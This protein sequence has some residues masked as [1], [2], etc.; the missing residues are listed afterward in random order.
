[1]R[2][3]QRPKPSPA[4]LPGF[5]FHPPLRPPF[6][7]ILPLLS[8]TRTPIFSVDIPSGWDVERGRQTLEKEGEGEGE[9]GGT[10]DTFEPQ[11]LISLTAPKEG[12]RE[13]TGRH[14]LGGR[15]I[16]E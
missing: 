12:V 5:S 16:P 10:V 11:G 6:T 2:R 4:D 1:M 15:F 7:S 14:W 9:G 13:Y 3:R 8:S